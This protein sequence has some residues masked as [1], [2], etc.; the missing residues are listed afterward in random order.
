[1][2]V[3]GRTINKES[4]IMEWKTGHPEEDGLYLVC[5]LFKHTN[6]RGET[7][8]WLEQRLLTWNSHYAVWDQEDGDDYYCDPEKIAYWMELPPMPP[9]PEEM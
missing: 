6:S 7:R 3:N 8:T 5:E 1:M 2:T 9:K 4:S